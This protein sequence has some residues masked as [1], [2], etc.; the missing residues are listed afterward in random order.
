MVAHLS[1]S[2]HYVEPSL[3]IKLKEWTNP[4]EHRNRR[5]LVWLLLDSPSA[6]VF[7]LPV[8]NITLNRKTLTYCVTL[9]WCSWK[10]LRDVWANTLS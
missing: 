10:C 1:C 8:G 9:I 4:A 3:E 6:I 5:I 7:V 2:T